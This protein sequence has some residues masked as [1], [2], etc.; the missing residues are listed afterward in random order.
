[1]PSKRWPYGPAH[2]QPPRDWIE[3]LFGK[4]SLDIAERASLL[5]G[6]APD[7]RADVGRIVCACHGIGEKRI[8]AGIQVQGLNSVEAI[9]EVLKAGSGCGSC[10]PEI[11]AMLAA[12]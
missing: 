8:Q 4:A 6:H 2:E 5:S 7:K 11:R 3:V 9:A 10:V 1:M 12:G